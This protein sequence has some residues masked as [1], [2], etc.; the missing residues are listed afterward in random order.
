MNQKENEQVKLELVDSG[1]A[2]REFLSLEL[3]DSRLERRVRRVAEELSSQPEYPINV[4]S[5]DAAATK[6]AY[7]LFQNERVTANRI[8]ASH[9]VRTLERM[10]KEFIVLA[11]QDT[12][13]FNFSHHNSKRGIGPIG[14]SDNDA[15]GLILHST[16]A[17]TPQGLPLGILTHSCWARKGYRVNYKKLEAVPIEEK[18]SYRW[19]QAL[20]ETSKLA[21]KHQTSIVVTIADRESDIFEFLQEAQKLNAKYVIRAA[22]DRHLQAESES[23]SKALAA[24]EIQGSV[25]LE[26]PTQKRKATFALKYVQ[27]AIRPPDRV[28][29]A[30]TPKCITCWVIE[31]VE[32]DPPDNAS[33]ISWTLLTNIAVTNLSHAIERVSWYRRRWSIE[34]YHKIMKSGCKIEDCR[35]QTGERL[36]RYIALFSVIAWRLFWIVHIKRTNPTAPATVILTQTEIKTLTSLQ[37]FKKLILNKNKLNANQ[38]VLAIACLG[39]YLNRKN[40][41][42]PGTIVIW[43]GW[44]RLTSMTELYNSIKPGCG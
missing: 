17:V 25:E 8:F 30:K 23:I 5:E 44:Q 28:S 21:V 26:I 37:R 19:V 9:Q 3:G 4:A 18:E 12:T 42:P 13:C 27:L 10:S 20:R 31:L 15:Q 1:W 2:E 40:D 24:T 34:E 35:L 39:G 43:R 7:R 36:K 41:P 14:S 33:P 32:Q 22:Y 16:L 29:R 6:A 11:I 38:A